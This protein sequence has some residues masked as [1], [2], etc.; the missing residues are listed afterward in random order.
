MTDR[1]IADYLRAAT[2]Q[3]IIEGWYHT[4]PLVQN[5]WVVN[6][7]LGAQQMSR[8]ETIGYVEMLKEAG[9]EPRPVT[10]PQ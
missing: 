3:N 6:S 2:A 8:A 5:D 4:G 7:S 10:R 1:L 9:I